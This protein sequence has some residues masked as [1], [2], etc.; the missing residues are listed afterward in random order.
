MVSETSVSGL[1]ELDAALK[2]FTAK[3]EGS[4]VRGG[5]RAGALAFR[6][7]AAAYIKD[8]TGA[9]RK[10]LRV[11]TRLKRGKVSATLVAGDKEAFYAHMVEFGTAPHL[12]KATG[13]SGTRNVA[14]RVNRVNKRAG[15]LAFGGVLVE[16]VNHPGS[17]PKP[18]MRPALD[19]GQ[20]DAVQRMADY[21]KKRIT[22]EQLK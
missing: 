1:K 15:G 16:Q 12:I 4:I 3:V 6:D 10:S 22:K 9:L 5:V 8:D 14:A 17:A 19:G 21:I 7:R 20:T 11:R 13:P 2:Q 18:F